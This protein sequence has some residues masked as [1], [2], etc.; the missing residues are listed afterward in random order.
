M[1][2]SKRGLCVAAGLLS[3][4]VVGIGIWFWQKEADYAA[5]NPHSDL[6]PI[7]EWVGIAITLLGAV[8]ILLSFAI[9]REQPGR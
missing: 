6:A 3:A 2:V 5:A 1:D 8:G 4:L 7:L 9:A